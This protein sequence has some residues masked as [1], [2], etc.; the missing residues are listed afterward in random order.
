MGIFNSSLEQAFASTG[1]LTGTWGATSALGRIIGAV[2]AT[3][4]RLNFLQPTSQG[5]ISYELQAFIPSM[6]CYAADASAQAELIEYLFGVSG[7]VAP[8]PFNLT[9]D[10]NNVSFSWID[11]TYLA[12]GGNPANASV[13]ALGN[14][15]Y[16]GIVPYRN[17]SALH[18]NDTTSLLPWWNSTVA[19]EVPVSGLQGQF[20]AAFP[21]AIIDL[22]TN[23][24]TLPHT[25]QT[26]IVSNYTQMQ[27]ITCQLC[28]A[29]IKVQVDFIN[30]VSNSTVLEITPI[31]N[32]TSQTQNEI[33]TASLVF[34]QELCTYL[35]G[36]VA[37]YLD[38][39][40]QISDYYTETS[41]LD[42]YMA[43]GAEIYYMYK[44]IDYLF[45]INSGANISPDN[46]KPSQTR[47]VTLAR[48]IENFVLNSSL[49]MLSDSTLWYVHRKGFISE[50][51]ISM[52]S[53]I[54]IFSI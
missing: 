44:N 50:L 32:I 24:W 17:V 3:G 15:G 1:G 5:N 18:L 11:W 12:D 14:I 49:S 23:N 6:S 47:N 46:L 30:G 4:Q 16:F 40:L 33:N 53:L 36:A 31:A 20:M 51:K 38:V 54:L 7:T 19:S 41:L 35:I 13:N 26:V 21:Q 28:N 52:S 39:G 34:F 2:A 9:P 27:F 42:T 8:F 45:N 25:N 22:P 37:W 48:D 29:S 43:T 10:L